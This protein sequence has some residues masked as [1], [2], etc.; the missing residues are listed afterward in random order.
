ME[1]CFSILVPIS[2]KKKK[3]KKK[4]PQLI[5]MDLQ[6]KSFIYKPSQSEKPR[7]S[8]LLCGLGPLFP[9]LQME[10]GME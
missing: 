7:V 6:S 5:E 3:E 4:T 1:W 2:V 9:H 10:Y 8:C